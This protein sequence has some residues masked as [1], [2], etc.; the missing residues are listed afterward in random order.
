MKEEKLYQN[1][2]PQNFF[3]LLSFTYY[4]YYIK[5][6]TSS[7]KLKISEKEREENRRYLSPNHNISPVVAYRI[8]L[9]RVKISKHEFPGDV[10]VCCFLCSSFV[11]YILPPFHSVIKQFIERFLACTFPALSRLPLHPA[12]SRLH[13]SWPNFF[14]LL[15]QSL[16]ELKRKNMLMNDCY[17]LMILLTRW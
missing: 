13:F 4:A 5:A 17:L 10:P 9:K 8:I 15:L 12:L 14:P 16:L 3:N 7:K 6:A 11:Y 2:V 1:F